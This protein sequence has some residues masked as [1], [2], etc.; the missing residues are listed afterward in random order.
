[1]PLLAVAGLS[2][3]DIMELRWCES[4]SS[5]FLRKLVTNYNG[6]ALMRQNVYYRAWS[7]SCPV[8]IMEVWIMDM[9]ACSFEK[10]GGHGWN[11]NS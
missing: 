11:W 7:N 9:S 8:M 2:K 4:R 3:S 5:I 6:T 10:D 1:M